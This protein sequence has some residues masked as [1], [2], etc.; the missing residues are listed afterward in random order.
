[1]PASDVSSVISCGKLPLKCIG[2]ATRCFVDFPWQPD[3]VLA[4]YTCVSICASASYQS[5]QTVLAN[6]GPIC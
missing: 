6:A 2:V 3:F 5:V 1:M 4:L